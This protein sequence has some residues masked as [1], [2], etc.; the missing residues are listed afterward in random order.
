MSGSENVSFYLDSDDNSKL[1]INDQFVMSRLTRATVVL[2]PAYHK[3]VVTYVEYYGAANVQLRMA[4]NVNGSSGTL[5]ALPWAKVTP[6][7]PGI[8]WPVQLLV[9]GVPALTACESASTDVLLA[10]QSAT[11]VE[12]ASVPS[13]AGG[14][15]FRAEGAGA[16]RR[17]GAS[18][19][20]AFAERVSCCCT[21]N[22]VG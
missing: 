4:Q 20:P 21:W 13:P 22:P 18:R 1:F 12:P 14:W 5:A 9:N 11:A 15:A 19:V 3:L 2:P 10:G 16:G 17:R 7:S 8:A 6:R